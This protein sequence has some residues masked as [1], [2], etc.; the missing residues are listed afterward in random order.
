MLLEI[1]VSGVNPN[2]LI[3]SGLKL[4]IRFFIDIPGCL[5]GRVGRGYHS[6]FYIHILPRKFSRTIEILQGDIENLEH[7]KQTL[8]KRLD[9]QT[10][11]TMLSDIS[12]G[13]RTLGGR[14][15]PYSSPFGSPFSARKGPLPGAGGGISPGTDVG[16]ESADGNSGDG[17]EQMVIQ[18]SP[19]LLARVMLDLKIIVTLIFLTPHLTSSHAYKVV[20]NFILMISFFKYTD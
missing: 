7:D 16:V 5:E 8:E 6:H 9:I 18:N 13:R 14:G 3:Q 11:K 2:K 1:Q 12:A 10:K 15:S 19:L 20:C 17:A 4:K